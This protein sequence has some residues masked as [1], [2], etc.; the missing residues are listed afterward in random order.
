MKFAGRKI[1][2]S[3]KCKKFMLDQL[4]GLYNYL[5][6]ISNRILTTGLYGAG[7]TFW[8]EC[9]QS[10]D[11]LRR[12]L[13]IAENTLNPHLIEKVTSDICAWKSIIHALD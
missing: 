13:W 12:I 4:A 2:V 6:C 11:I 7:C 9:L 10:D 1:N 5:T 8:A 3:S